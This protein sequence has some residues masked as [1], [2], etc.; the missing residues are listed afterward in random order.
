MDGE[1]A[2]CVEDEVPSTSSSHD[3]QLTWKLLIALLSM[4]HVDRYWQMLLSF[5]DSKIS[6]VEGGPLSKL[7]TDSTSLLYFYPKL[8]P[9]N[10][11]PSNLRDG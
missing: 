5:V 2:K 4:D 6:L 7:Q 10:L 9:I 11:V 3:E 1:G 8:F